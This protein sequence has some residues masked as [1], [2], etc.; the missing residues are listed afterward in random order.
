MS[1]QGEVQQ[2]GSADVV[3]MQRL[4]DVEKGLNAL[5]AEFARINADYVATQATISLLKDNDGRRETEIKQ[6]K[7]A[8]SRMEIQFNAIM[9]RF[10]TMENRLFVIIGDAGKERSASQK[11]WIDTFKFVV[12]GTIAVIASKLFLG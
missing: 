2:G 7:D 4:E 12:G 9:G 10:D 11:L 5:S 6:I 8:T 1:E 3:P